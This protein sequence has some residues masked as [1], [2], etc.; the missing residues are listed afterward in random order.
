[1]Y[2]VQYFQRDSKTMLVEA[3]GDR[4]VVL[5]DGRN[6][7]RT[8]KEDVMRYNGNHRPNYDAYRI[9]QGDTFTRSHP[10]TELISLTN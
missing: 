6:N 3:C 10:I 5:L 9:Y 1:M 8:M 2:Y 4:S 7:L